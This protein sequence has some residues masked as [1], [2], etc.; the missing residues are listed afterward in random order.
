[1]NQTLAICE[2]ELYSLFVSPIAYIVSAC[3]LLIYG[4]FFFSSTIA[5]HSADIATAMNN[6]TII[7]FMLN[8]L[9]S[10]KLLSEEKKNGTLELLLTSPIHTLHIVI[11]KLLASIVL[12]ILILLLTLTGPIYLEVVSDVYWPIVFI[13]YLGLF[14]MGASVLGIGLV[15]SAITENQIISGMLSVSTS[16]GLFL[17][18][19]IANS[20]SGVVRKIIDELTI[21]AHYGAFNRG[22]FDLKDTIYYCLWIVL[23]ILLA[24]KF[25]ENARWK[26]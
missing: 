17:I 10:M 11:G 18:S 1:M 6:M 13:Q 22:V 20:T 25:T 8:P 4:I 9:I 14:L 3:F 5:N 26:I 2:R 12:F 24:Y 19:W 23:A 7:I 15:F 21:L 16:L